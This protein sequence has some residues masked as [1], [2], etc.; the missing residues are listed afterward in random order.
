MNFAEIPTIRRKG[1]TFDFSQN[2]NQK[3]T[4]K[5]KLIK[6]RLP[7]FASCDIMYLSEIKRNRVARTFFTRFESGINTL[8][9]R[10]I[11]KTRE[12]KRKTG[13]SVTSDT[14]PF[15]V[16]VTRLELAAST[17][18]R[19]TWTFFW[20]FYLFSDLSATAKM[21]FRALVASC[22]QVL[23]SCLWSCMWS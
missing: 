7:L 6:K 16:W 9:T 18:P 14:S 5:L 12:N 8:N 1:W 13:Q 17:T 11:E 20:S 15:L 3:V 10:K 4:H 23:R 22:L 19:A 2:N 21:T